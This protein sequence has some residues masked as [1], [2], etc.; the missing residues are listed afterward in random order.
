MVLDVMEDLDFNCIVLTCISE[1]GKITL[2]TYKK[3]KM[4]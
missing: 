2:R 3:L 1:F 4:I